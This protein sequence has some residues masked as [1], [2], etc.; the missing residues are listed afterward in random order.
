MP[1]AV[2]PLPLKGSG[3]VGGGRRGPH[4]ASA[5][6]KTTT[7]YSVYTRL[8]RGG[9][10]PAGLKCTFSEKLGEMRE[11]FRQK[12]P[13]TNIHSAWREYP[14]TETFCPQRVS[15]WPK[16]SP[17]VTKISESNSMSALLNR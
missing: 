7:A 1:L 4:A 8:T 5:A 13:S 16:T 17:H 11:V 14:S 2:D 15:E 3:P 10:N 9:S 12:V 6:A